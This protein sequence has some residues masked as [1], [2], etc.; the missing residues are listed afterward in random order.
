MR[1]LAALLVIALL[2]TGCS[3]DEPVQVGASGAPAADDGALTGTA[4]VLESPEHGPQ[5]CLGGVADSYPPQCGGPDIVGGDW[6]AAAREESAHGTTWGEYTVVGTYADGTFT[7]TE[8]PR[9]PERLDAAPEPTA[10]TPCPEPAGGWRAVDAAMT[11]PATQDAAMAAAR[12][13]GDYSGAWVDQSINPAY[14][15]GELSTEEEL[16]MNDPAAL[17]L[18]VRFTGDVERHEAELRA[19]WGGAL[20]VSEGRH[21]EAEL[22]RVQQELSERDDLLWSGTDTIG[23]QVELGV[24]VDDGVQAEMD[25][26]YGEGV[27]DVQPAL[28]PL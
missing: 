1:R 2:A 8:P 11:T 21:T 6:T 24:V 25:E 14:A 27:V 16:S 5:L 19:L 10:S 20:C 3:D 7:V 17:I 4:T 15:D 22:V 28:T 18:N 12:A 13:E 9:A 23:E 26:R